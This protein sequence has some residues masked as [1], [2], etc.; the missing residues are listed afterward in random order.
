MKYLLQNQKS[1]M[2]FMGLLMELV[3]H[4]FEWGNCDQKRTTLYVFSY[5]GMLE[6]KPSI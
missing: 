6:F 3:K 4:H 2:R 1:I 5:M